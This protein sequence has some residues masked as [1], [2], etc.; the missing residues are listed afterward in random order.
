MFARWRDPSRAGLHGVGTGALQEH[1]WS[2]LRLGSV[3]VRNVLFISEDE[4]ESVDAF[5]LFR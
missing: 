4:G 1:V 5:Q 2:I 3:V